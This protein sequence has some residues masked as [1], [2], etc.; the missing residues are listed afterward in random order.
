MARVLLLPAFLEPLPFEFGDLFDESL[1]FVVI[2]H[3]LT[4]PVFPGLGDEKVAQ[5][6]LAA[7]DQVEGSMQLA[8]RATAIVTGHIVF[9]RPSYGSSQRDLSNW[10]ASEC[11]VT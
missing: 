9:L 1:Y 3:R 6:P 5:L 11:I 10:S 2:A 8:A 4:D 7:L